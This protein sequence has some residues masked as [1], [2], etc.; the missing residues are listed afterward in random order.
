MAED[1]GIVDGE[2]VKASFVYPT[3]ILGVFGQA[4]E[5]SCRT[6]GLSE[7]MIEFRKLGEDSIPSSEGARRAIKYI[8]STVGTGYCLPWAR[9]LTP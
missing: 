4:L 2:A 8:W 5:S 7:K 6:V 9:S 1:R 3:D